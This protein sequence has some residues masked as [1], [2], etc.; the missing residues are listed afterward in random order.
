MAFDGITVHALTKELSDKLTGGRLSKIAQP[1]KD[2][3][4]FTIK[5]PNGQFRLMISVNPSL[6]LAYLTDNNKQSPLTAPNFCM[7]LRKH[8]ANGR[9]ISITQP[10]LER[11]INFEIEHLNEMGDLC[12]KYLI[13]ELM[14]KHSNIIFTDDNKKI[15]DSIKRINAGISSVR[16]VLP[17]FEYFI[18]NTGD[19]H[20]PL[21]TNREEFVKL[22]STCA[23]PL[24]KALYTVY[25]GISPQAAEEICY[26]A[27]IDT[28]RS[29][30]DLTENE[31]LHLASIFCNFMDEIKNNSFSPVIIY[32]NSEPVDF[33]V[34]EPS[35]YDK[36][37]LTYIDSI[38]QMLDSYYSGKNIVSRIHQRSADLRQIISSNLERNYKKYDL[39]LKQL[40]DTDKRDK[41][42]IYGELLNT[43]GYSIE[44]GADKCEVLNYYTNENISIPLDT[45]KTPQENSQKYFAKY[46]KLK[47]TYEALSELVLE[48]KNEIDHLESISTS[49]DIATTY[50]DLIQIKEEL[51]QY[52]YMKNKTNGKKGRTEKSKSQPFH[53]VSS[54][55]F[56]I[57]VGKNNIQNEELTFKAATGNDWWFHAKNMPGSHVIVK[58][59]NK[60]LPDSTYEQAAKL[61]AYYSKGRDQEKVEIDY[62]QKKQVKKVNGGAP[63][64]VIYHTNYS[65]NIEPDIS[66]IELINQ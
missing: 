9:I 19:K 39:Q 48:T 44:S 30:S 8:I 1:E 50:D 5:A 15:I 13:I 40:Q 12:K 47:R 65:M 20:N 27:E 2:E 10:G 33:C 42:R 6:P 55:G 21:D 22:I 36:M 31:R 53:Y 35:I 66:G 17:G 49:L 11:I 58:S 37:N 14:G 3:L 63:G 51:V 62:V 61:A 43:Y 16:E 41:Y 57:Y 23:L 54:D 26:E 28:R 7:L 64:F 60:D 45:D 56:H 46:N 34:Y 29:P 18:P 25:T 4:F 38:S 32:D 59:D 24:T 52:G